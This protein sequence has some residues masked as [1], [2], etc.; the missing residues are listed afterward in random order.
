MIAAIKQHRLNWLAGFLGASTGVAALGTMFT[1][2]SVG[3]WY[4]SL[5]R[6]SW[7]PPKTAFAPVWTTLYLLMSISAWLVTGAV[8][9][10]V[11]LRSPARLAL[12]AWVAQ[13]ALNLAWSGVFFGLRRTGASVFVIGGLWT[14]IVAY[15]V[16][17]ARI[18]RL[19][20]WLFAP[21][22]AWVSLASAL[23]FQIWRMNRGHGSRLHTDSSE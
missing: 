10:R 8:K 13:L 2:R 6:P 9:D 12:G 23:N 21:Y 18:S 11:E 16:W 19:A 20:A 22:L 7:S 15:I 5:A 14:A 4:N 3:S 1:A 17:A